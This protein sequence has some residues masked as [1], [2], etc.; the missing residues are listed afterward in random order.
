MSKKISLFLAALLVA[1]FT[2]C[3]APQETI[4]TPVEGEEQTTP[5]GDINLEEVNEFL[6]TSAGLGPGSIGNVVQV[7]PHAHIDGPKNETPFYAFVNFKYTARD[8][9][10][11]QVTYLSCTCRSADVNFWQTAYIELSLPSSKKIEDAEVVTLS[12]DKDSTNHYLGGFWGDS[13]PTPAGVTYETFKTEYLPFFEGKNQAYMK[14]ISTIWDIKAED[15]TTG[16]GRTDFTI[17]TFSG[18]SVSA[19]NIIRIINALMDYH[20]TD[21]F[22]Q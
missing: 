4:E 21:E 20:A 5:A 13:N 16:E 11:Y 3:A 2:G 8:Y 7:I 9:I 12:F 19:N 18:S 6:N 22:F 14:A 15:Y 10:K 17:D 1:S